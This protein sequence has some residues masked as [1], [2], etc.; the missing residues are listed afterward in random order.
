MQS[1]RVPLGTGLTYHLL[2]WGGEGD[3]PPADPGHTVVLLHGFLDLGSSWELAVKAGLE[4]T[5]HILAPDMRGHGD[6]DRVGA[7]GYYHFADYLADLHE[8]LRLRARDRV[9]LV[10][11][12]MGGAIASY[13]AGAFPERIARLALLEGLGP[14]EPTTS[15][16]ERIRAWIRAWERVR[17]H[18]QR[19]Y[20]DVQE[21]AAQLRKH[22]PLLSGEL[23]IQLAERGTSAGPDGRR[24]FKHDP[25]HATPGPYPFRLDTARELWGRVT[26]PVLLV[27]GAESVFR[28]P[29]EE[30][31]RRVEAFSSAASVESL[32]IQ[33]A[34]HMMLRHR[35]ADIAA[36]LSGFLI[37][38]VS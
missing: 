19:S 8:L 32:T 11:H 28:H 18:G 36:A 25:L 26:C 2:E 17:G 16:P 13:Y 38:V 35:P 22:D 34:A 30:R 4:G 1:Q 33:G 7:G 21:A 29:P 27:E 24:R 6:S 10:G 9:S 23:A 31:A 3:P 37:G 5:F 20:S 12:S 15:T 14:P